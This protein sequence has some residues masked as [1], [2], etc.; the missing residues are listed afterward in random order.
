MKTVAVEPAE[1]PV[2]SGGKGGIKYKYRS[3]YIQPYII[4]KYLFLQNLLL[5]IYTIT[6]TIFYHILII[7]GPHK[8]Q[9]IGA[10]F[11]FDEEFHDFFLTMQDTMQLHAVLY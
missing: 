8:I 1:S 3:I 2:L 9:G 7:I 10:G 11:V 4:H 5:K 6:I